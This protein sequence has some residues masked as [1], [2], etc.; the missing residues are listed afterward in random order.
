MELERDD[1]YRGQGMPLAYEQVKDLVEAQKAHGTHIDTKSSTMLAVATALVGLAVPLVLGQ[2]WSGESFRYSYILL[3]A[4][5]LPITTY[6]VTACFFVRTYTLKN[7]LDVNDPNEV[8]SI[9]KLTPEAA[10]ESLY[11]AIEKAYSQNKEIN[12]RKV[13]NFRWLLKAVVVQTFFIIAWSFLVA[14]FSLGT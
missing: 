7:Y 8:K 1:S 12:D 4:T 14:L 3:R 9:I 10:R 6:L 2:F 5:L 11:K 13:K